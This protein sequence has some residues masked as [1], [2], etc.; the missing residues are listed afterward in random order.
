MT[1][2][3]YRTLKSLTDNGTSPMTVVASARCGRSIKI[4]SCR[5]EDVSL[6]PCPQIRGT[7]PSRSIRNIPPSGRSPRGEGRS[8]LHGLGSGCT[9]EGAWVGGHQLSRAWRGHYRASR[10][11]RTRLP[12]TAATDHSGRPGRSHRVP[13]L[14]RR[15]TRHGASPFPAKDPNFARY[16]LAA[17]RAAA[18]RSPCPVCPTRDH[19]HMTEQG[20][21]MVPPTAALAL[22]SCDG[23]GPTSCRSSQRSGWLKGTAAP[24]LRELAGRQARR[25]RAGGRALAGRKD[26]GV[27]TEGTRAVVEPSPRVWH[28]PSR[29]CPHEVSAPGRSPTS[30]SGSPLCQDRRFRARIE[31]ASAL[32][33]VKVVRSALQIGACT[34]RCDGARVGEAAVLAARVGR[35]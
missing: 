24:R 22:P 29:R 4:G 5:P 25:A 10:P 13:P 7:M 16:S 21:L 15:L 11:R 31:G 34:C 8:A 27:T 1:Y 28:R 6:V 23:S 14:R 26:A 30:A 2:I 32:V 18:A 19:S 3:A 12:L 17:V 20:L 33:G 9:G 35:G